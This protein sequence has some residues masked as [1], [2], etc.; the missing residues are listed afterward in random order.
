MYPVPI[1]N[2]D[3]TR[4]GA[5]LTLLLRATT[6]TATLRSAMNESIFVGLV[7]VVSASAIAHLCYGKW[8]R[9]G[10][11]ISGLTVQHYFASAN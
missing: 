1:R 5:F 8:T 2:L 11:A 6:L 7:L 4:D 9:E 3:C 10:N